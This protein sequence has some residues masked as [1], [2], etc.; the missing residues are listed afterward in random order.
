[1]MEIFNN[2]KQLGKWG[3]VK[4]GWGRVDE[5]VFVYVERV[6]KNGDWE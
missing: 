2:E 3:N 1:M 4:C 6:L 5:R